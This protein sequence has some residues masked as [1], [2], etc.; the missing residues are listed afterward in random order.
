VEE[1]WEPCKGKGEEKMSTLGYS[2]AE[3]ERQRK[4]QIRMEFERKRKEK[5]RKEIEG[6]LKAIKDIEYKLA[7]SEDMAIV[8]KEMSKV[9][10]SLKDIEHLIES[11][12]D[13][14]YKIVR[15]SYTTV[16]S[17]ASL[18]DS[19][20][21]E[22]MMELDEL[23]IDISIEVE[24]ATGL[25][26]KAII[27]SHKTEIK[28]IL[29]VL[30]GLAYDLEKGFRDAV[31]D[32]LVKEK[33]RLV[34][35]EKQIEA[36]KIKE[37]ERRYII[38]SLKSTMTELGFI[39]GKPKMVSKEDQVLITGKM[40]SGRM[41]SFKVGNSGEMEFDLDGYEGRE[42]AKELEHVMEKMSKQFEITCEPPQHKWKNPDR[43]SKGS[44]DLP[45][46]GQTMTRRG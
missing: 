36:S 20:K 35:I 22:K 15:K 31:E 4:E 8:S 46:G 14:A 17:L 45:T 44:K 11:D 21:V 18:A 3:L 38:G 2:K 26:S 43:I 41:A 24:F 19:R 42:C 33:E 10:E 5:L 12:V 7:S 39:V 37:A 13:S 32:R 28:D 29:S 16:G 6:M 34:S 1:E 40:P 30:N 27:N 25:L 23:K 9:K